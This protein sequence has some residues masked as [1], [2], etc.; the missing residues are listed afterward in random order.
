[1]AEVLGVGTAGEV[2]DGG[3]AVFHLRFDLPK[4]LLEPFAVERLYLDNYFSIAKAQRDLGYQPMFTT[5]R[6][7]AECLPYYVDLFHQMKGA[8]PE[9]DTSLHFA[10]NLSLF[11][12]FHNF[13]ANK[14]RLGAPVTAAPPAG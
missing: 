12:K 11:A 9:P 6:A 2:R 5:E 10:R 7:L 4:P 1:M 13:L 8:A 3:V 14:L